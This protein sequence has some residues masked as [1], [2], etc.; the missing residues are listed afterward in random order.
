MTTNTETQITFALYAAPYEESDRYE[1][2]VSLSQ[3]E[4]KLVYYLAHNIIV[5]RVTKA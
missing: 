3:A 2:T 4:E 5:E 1:E